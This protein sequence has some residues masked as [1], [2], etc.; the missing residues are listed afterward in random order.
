MSTIEMYVMLTSPTS[1]V[2]VRD[3]SCSPR[4]VLLLIST[5]ARVSV[6]S[7]TA[8]LIEDHTYAAMN[9]LS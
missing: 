7:C 2:T 5:P 4:G 3:T 9:P 1:S 6:E 8:T